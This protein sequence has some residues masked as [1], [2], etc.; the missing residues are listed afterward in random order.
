[1][2]SIVWNLTLFLENAL[3]RLCDYVFVV[4]SCDNVLLRRFKKNR[5]AD[6]SVIWNFPSIGLLDKRTQT[7]KIGKSKTIL[8][9]GGI[10][11]D[12]GALILLEATARL[13]T[14]FSDVR[15]L[16]VGP[17]DMYQDLYDHIEEL[18]LK[19]NVEIR[20]SVPHF[21]IWRIYES[22][23]ISVVLYQPTFWTLRTMASEKLFE[24]MMFSLP[25]VASNFPGL[26]KIVEPCSCGIL[27][28]PTDSEEVSGKIAQLLRDPLLS[29]NLGKNGRD[30]ILKTYNWENE[31]NKVLSSYRALLSP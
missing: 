3:V 17:S 25:V 9:V 30:A 21:D 8:Y 1:M 2:R 14:E 20:R 10:S 18:G 26:R 23:G 4:P 7:A 15:V 28:D 12:K 19:E 29:G 11:R 22:A 24:S 16:M 27:V 13:V 31:E 6:V 5:K